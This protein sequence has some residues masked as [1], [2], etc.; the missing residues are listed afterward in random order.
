MLRVTCQTLL[1]DMNEIGKSEPPPQPRSQ[2]LSSS[3]PREMLFI[4]E[5]K[6]KLNKQCDSIRAK[7]FINY[8]ILHCF[9]GAVHLT[10]R[11]EGG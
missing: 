3:R 1:Q 5:F 2:G 4:R 11:G 10:L 7:L 8:P 6:P 9:L